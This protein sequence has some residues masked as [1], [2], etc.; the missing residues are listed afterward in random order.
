MHL[1]ISTYVFHSNHCSLYS[2]LTSWWT[3]LKCF[4]LNDLY[5]KMII[6]EEF[7]AESWPF[8]CF[9]TYGICLFPSCKYIVPLNTV[10]SPILS[11][12]QLHY[13]NKWKVLKK[14]ILAAQVLAKLW[15]G[16]PLKNPYYQNF[17]FST[18]QCLKFDT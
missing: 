1:T 6:K 5:V 10:F 12:S 4:Q 7:F 18:P 16:F 11:R 17:V 14:G 2:S 13:L 9:S 8:V 3:W 15:R